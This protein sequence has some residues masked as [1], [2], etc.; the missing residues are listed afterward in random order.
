MSTTGKRV[1]VPAAACAISAALLLTGC[2]SSKT[3]AP[4]APGITG[5]Q[6]ASAAPSASPSASPSATPAPTAVLP[7]GFTIQ[8]DGGPTGDPVKDAVLAANLS[9]YRAVFQAVGKQNADDSLYQLWTGQET[10][11]VNA[12]QSTEKYIQ[13]F[14]S[15]GD[16]IYGTLRVYDRNVTLTSASKASLTW[17]EDQTKTFDKVVATGKVLYN[18]PSRAS[19]TYYRSTLWKNSAGRWITVWISGLQG[20]S[21][22]S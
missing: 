8:V 15:G 6:S 11:L 13:A 17:C 19:Y 9:Y 18:A 10:V 21:R 2:G 4:A 3:A 1:T 22:C 14:I 16:S 5:A 7:A 12:R 20:D